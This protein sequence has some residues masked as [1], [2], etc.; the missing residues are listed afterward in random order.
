MSDLY[1]YITPSGVIVPDTSTLKDDVD[2]EWTGVFGT[3]MSTDSST[4]QGTVIATD[5]AGRS[6]LVNNN[7]A[8]ANQI[9]PN[10]SAGI[11]LDAIGALSGL[12]READ[13]ATI[14]NN[15]VLAG[16]G[17]SPIV[18]GSQISSPA[19]DLFALVSDVTLD[20][21]TMQALGQYQAVV[22]GPIPA[23]MGVYTIETQAL[24]LE[25]VTVTVAGILGTLEQSDE[26]YRTLRTKTLALQ[27]V[28]L[29]EAS[30]STVNAVPGVTGSQGIDNYTGA[31]LTVSGVTVPAD[32]AWFC[33]DG[34]SDADVA[35]ALFDN[36]SM[37]CGW[38][39][40]A[41]TVTETITGAYGQT[42]TV[43]FDRPTLVPILVRVTCKQGTFTGNP[44]AAV[45]QACLDYGANVVPNF[46]GLQVGVSAS[47]FE[48][49]AAV[50]QECPGLYVSKVELSLSGG[51][52]SYAPAELPML[53]FQKGTIASGAV[54][55]VVNT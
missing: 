27:G 33:V 19:G 22:G 40:A 20:P 12:I 5:V 47:P 21:V 42:Y 39:G 44:D 31:S 36:K 8:L 6:A 48:I 38:Y 50:M 13:T 51:T 37:G 43:V 52:P 2:S 10:Q 32:K 4:P 53:L 41:N 45:V 55:V 46:Q 9:N 34:G 16:V 24:G 17:G 14:I 29:M 35:Q 49:S 3:G 7:A 54:S 25:T 23:P 15:V 30:Q 28:G 18:A 26:S 11:F 1:N